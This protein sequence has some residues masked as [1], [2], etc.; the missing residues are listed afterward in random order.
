MIKKIPMTKAG[1][2]KLRSDLERLV[3]VERPKNIQAISEARAHGD[4]S[5]NA[6]YHAAKERQS[7]IEGRIQELQAKIA[8]AQVIDVAS[9]QHSKV[10]FG[11]T[12]DL[13]DGESGEERS[14]TLVGVD[15][16][17]VKRGRISVESPIGRALIGHEVGD[18]VTI[19]TPART[20]DYEILSIRFD[21][22][23]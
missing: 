15:E 10:V 2:E 3:K 12:V 9:I 20:V 21:E 1:Y 5:E 23:E 11:A 14:Y 13:E 19:R 4:L 18:V 22:V 6:E 17:D 16:I 8:H 7:F